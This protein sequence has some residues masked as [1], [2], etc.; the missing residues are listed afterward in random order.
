MIKF[1]HQAAST[2]LLALGNCAGEVEGEI[3]VL[4]LDA[5]ARSITG[6][7]EM[8]YSLLS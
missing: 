6:C 4:G 5:D 8:E 3:T 2:L 1:S 7:F